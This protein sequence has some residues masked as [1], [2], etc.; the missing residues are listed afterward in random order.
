MA[1]LRLHVN[2]HCIPLRVQRRLA[3]GCQP[4]QLRTARIAHAYGDYIVINFNIQYYYYDKITEGCCM[5]RSVVV[6]V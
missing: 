6:T 3:F 2:A 4:R 1:G 5:L